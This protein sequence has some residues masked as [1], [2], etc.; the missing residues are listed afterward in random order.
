[1]TDGCHREEQFMNSYDIFDTLIGRWGFYPRSIFQE[2]EQSGIVSFEQNRKKA[3][4]LSDGTYSGIYKQYQ[5]LTGISDEERYRIKNLEFQLE[6][7]RTFPIVENVRKL[8]SDSLIISDMYFNK[9]ELGE[10]LSANG[11]FN[12][13]EIFCGIGIK[14]SGIIWKTVHPDCHL[15][16]NPHVCKVAEEN[17]IPAEQY[18]NCNFTKN[19][20]FLIDNGYFNVACLSRA[21]RLSNPQIGK[22]EERV[23]NDQAETNI[24]FLILLSNYIASFAQEKDF[25]SILFTERD[26]IS[27][28]NIFKRLFPKKKSK[29]F[30]SCRNLYNY[31]SEEFIKYVGTTVSPK[32][33]V[34]DL[35]SSGKT[36]FKFFNKHIDFAPNFFTVVWCDLEKVNPVH[37]LLHQFDGWTDKI[38][39]LNYSNVG[40]LTDIKEGFSVREPRLESERKYIDIQ[41]QAMQE[42]CYFL[43]S[44]FKVETKTPSLLLFEYFV[45]RMQEDCIISD[46]VNH[47]II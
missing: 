12:Y 40:K 45:K 9:R 23:W 21:V 20:Q 3:E 29:R 32:D 5:L 42:A 25:S 37:Y 41:I 43:D 7:S 28:Y 27:L 14:H 47:W 26:C 39:K 8:D 34:V 1:M 4:C 10:I 38:E 17:G 46:L 18:T 24:P 30:S 35:Q 19:E 6:K 13:R 36:I 15:D 22:T 2:I 44:G 16:D 11:I 31:P 33:L